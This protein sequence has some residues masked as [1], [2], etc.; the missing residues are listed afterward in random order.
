MTRFGETTPTQALVDFTMETEFAD[1]PESVVRQGKRILLDAVGCALAGHT[2][3]KAAIVREFIEEMGDQPRAGII[4][5]QKT[6]YPLAAFAN[7][8]LINALDYDSMGPITGHVTPYVTPPCLAMAERVRSPGKNLITATVMA[9]EV[10]GRI[11]SSMAQRRVLKAEPPYYEDSP[12]YSFSPTVF[13]AV[14]GA[15]KLLHLDGEAVANA[16]G[17]AGASTPVPAGQKWEQTAR[18]GFMV[19]YNCWAGWIAQLATVA[20]L[21]AEKGFTG[22]STILDGDWGFWKI[23]GSPFFEPE[24]L[25][26]G[27]GRSWHLNDM[28]F[29]AY[30]CCTGNQSGID[31]INRIMRESG[32][33]AEAIQQVLVQGAPALLCPCRAGTDIREPIDTQF[34]NAYVFAVAAYHGRRP[35]PEWQAPATVSDPRISELMT[36]VRVEL[37]PGSEELTAMS[38]KAKQP[39]FRNTLVEITAGG[40]KFTAQVEHSKGSPQNPMT[41][42]ELK[43]KFRNNARCALGQDSLVEEII[44]MID[45]LENVPDVTQLTR[46]WTPNQKE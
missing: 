9:H 32:I 41:D 38:I 4:G 6:S 8:E 13:G 46:L 45:N 35:S 25:T 20:A 34:I 19:K 3:E 21:L 39:A 29:K 26:G 14:A 7:G 23:V 44:D 11:L 5:G 42:E 30:P 28:T 10:G 36:K 12:R 1:L 37:Y 16:F 22:D 43:D 27:L 40:R 2:T 31:A 24:R 15:S 33:E 18:G 17:I